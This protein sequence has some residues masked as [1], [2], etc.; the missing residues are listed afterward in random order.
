MFARIDASSPQQTG[1]AIPTFTVTIN[2][3]EANEVTVALPISP[4]TQAPSRGQTQEFKQFPH[5]SSLNG[6]KSTT[7]RNSCGEGKHHSYPSSP[8]R[9]VAN[10]VI[11]VDDDGNEFVQGSAD[12]NH[13][14]TA[15]GLLS[16]G[17]DEEEEEDRR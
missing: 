14:K 3:L 17:E 7:K 8:G 16:V 2:P 1:F 5:I 4:S 15:D 10:T 13:S 6:N 11:I 9:S 12:D